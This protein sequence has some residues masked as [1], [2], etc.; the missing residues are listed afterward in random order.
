MVVLYTAGRRICTWAEA[1][2]LFR[3]MVE[4]KR[5][6]LQ[7]FS[8]TKEGQPIPVELEAVVACVFL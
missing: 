8:W 3:E 2:K 1:E 5:E 4:G 7:T 6:H